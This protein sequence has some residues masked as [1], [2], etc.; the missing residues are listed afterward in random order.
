MTI[1]VEG[2]RRRLMTIACLGFLM[3]SGA[4]CSAEPTPVQTSATPTS[5]PVFASDEEALA[6]ATEAYEEYLSLSSVVAHEGGSD[7]Q[8]LAAVTTGEALVTEV[9]SLE[10]MSRAGTVGVGQ[11]KF[12]SFELQ[13][14]DLST[15]TLSAYVCL[16]VSATDV[17][18][19]S[20]TSVV[21]EDRRERIPLELGFLFEDEGNRLL[22]ERTRTWDGE[23]FCSLQ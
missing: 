10:G 15:G 12:D 7:A 9:E 22:L 19:T 18:D 8:R 20:G 16:D 6:A 13:S 3:I 5:A 11:L 2:S 14:A 4:G 23:N 21:P 1:D 17:L